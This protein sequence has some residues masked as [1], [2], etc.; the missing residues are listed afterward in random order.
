MKTIIRYPDQQAWWMAASP[1]MVASSEP[2]TPT[3]IEC[4]AAWWKAEDLSSG[5]NRGLPRRATA[6]SLPVTSYRDRSY[7][8][9]TMAMPSPDVGQH[10]MSRPAVLLSSTSTGSTLPYPQH[11]ASPR[12]R[13]G[14]RFNFLDDDTS[15]C[16]SARVS[17]DEYPGTP[18]CLA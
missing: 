7:E 4:P 6:A 17:G 1:E 14:Y 11:G 12:L 5:G 2:A 16:E 9:F 15:A 18:T 10:Q 8:V 3:V 13:G